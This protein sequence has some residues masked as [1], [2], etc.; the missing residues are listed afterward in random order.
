[1][2]MDMR[3]RRIV[4]RRIELDAPYGAVWME[5]HRFDLWASSGR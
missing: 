2:V 4:V 5:V 3:L 1:M